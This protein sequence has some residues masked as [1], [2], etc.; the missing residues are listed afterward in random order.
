MKVQTLSIVVPTKRCVNNCKFCVSKT[1]DNPY[2]NNAKSEYFVQDMRRRLEYAD[3]Q[4]VD[5]IILTGTGEILQNKS[6]LILLDGLLK[7][8]PDSFPIIEVQTSGVML[9]DENLTFLR[10]MGVSTISL[11]VSD[12]FDDKNNME[13]IG[14]PEKIRFELDELTA[15]IVGFGFNVRLSL[16]LVKS[17]TV[18]PAAYFEKAKKMGVAQITFRELYCSKNDTEEDKWI[19]ENKANPHVIEEINQYIMEH[20]RALYTLPFG[21]TV[22]SVNGISTVLDLDCM[23]SK[24]KV[25]DD[26]LKYLILREN[27]HIYTHWD[28]D[29]SMRF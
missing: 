1:H 10:D 2:C 11:S 26:V 15:K 6:F 28:D 20:G 21:A 27:G 19:K 3:H 16:N 7:A 13:I 23:V 18:N 12:M 22:F 24:K 29:G 5:T 8:M 9:D 17:V 14:T 4:G 25:V